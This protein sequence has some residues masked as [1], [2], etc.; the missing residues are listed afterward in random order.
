MER[1]RADISGRASRWRRKKEPPQVE[2]TETGKKQ[3]YDALAALSKA[4]LVF[5]VSYGA[6]GGFLNAYS[7]EFNRV[8]CMGGILGLSLLL[9]FVYE[10]EKKWFTNLCVI[11]I[12]IIYAY[13]AVSRFYVLNSGTYA[14]INEVY[15]QA[16]A[17]LG[18]VGGG[19][20]NLQVD[21]SYLTI[22]SI[23]LFIGVVLVILMVIRLQYKASLIRTI[24]MTFTLYL[25]PIYFEKTP[26][27]F[28]LFLLLSGYVTIGILQCAKVKKHL[29]AQ[30]KQALP[31][32]I[33]I[34]GAIVL[35]FAVLLPKIRYRAMVPKNAAKAAT[36]QDAALFAQYGVMALFMNNFAGGGIN[37]G[38]L[39]QN[40]TMMPDNEPDLLV[41]Y[42]PYSMDPVYLKAFTG[43]DY[44]GKKW[45]KATEVLGPS[46]GLLQSEVAG[47]AQLYERDS[48]AQARGVMEV[49]C[50]D[51]KEMFSFR[52][53]YAKVEESNLLP[54]GD[55]PEGAIK[56][57]RY[58]YYPM[59]TDE[60]VP[61]LD[62]H[63]V[64]N[65]YLNVP[66]NC[67]SAVA[68]ACKEAKLEGSAEEIAQQITEF[69]ASKYRYTLRPGYYFGSMDYISYFLSK[70]KKGFCTHFAS[71]GTMMLRYMG[72]PA[73]Y[74]EGYVFTYT[75]VVTDGEILENE[76]YEDY[77][78]G[79]APLGDTA[80]LEVEVPDAQGHAWIEM[81]LVDKG[82]VVVEVTPA[83][84]AEEEEETGGFWDAIM[85]AGNQQNS[86]AAK[87]QQE[88]AQYIENALAGGVTVVGVLAGIAA[89][90][91]FLRW[92]LGF[93]KE[94][95]LPA[96][97]R[98]RL[99]YGRMTEW[100]KD[101]D[102]G[103]AKL[104]TPEEELSWIETWYGLPEAGKL[105][106]GIYRTFFAPVDDEGCEELRAQ[107]HA[108]RKS[109]R[110]TKR[111]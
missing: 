31:I 65:R 83:A 20:Y 105:K 19:L 93:Y 46:E 27:T 76:N 84:I 61:G 42:T 66:I 15:E 74:V 1:T 54:V 33:A 24:L 60:S 5:M 59:V 103:F 51:P 41:R 94:S 29:S 90:V 85:N 13:M 86:E 56:G 92:L 78:D 22:T 70:N 48:D 3:K 34:G 21:D 100:L 14:V 30:I 73:R 98:L 2:L 26:D 107:V 28:C 82:W 39:S 53:Y 23:S 8:L 18:V 38:Q 97:E 79:Y 55:I 71:A 81:Y 68:S 75:D 87:A 44:D 104:T 35:I 99:E 57:E 77:Y 45:S 106:E 88:A 64:D 109:V 91:L 16:Q 80:V 17:Y 49:Y 62:W 50:L 25:V 47:R 63:E 67:R 9:S 89:L 12:F 72:I 37:E 32:G 40:V 102:E 69:F 52:P 10:T 111:R 4:L 95:K 7:I 43:V 36:E 96:K 101:R 11:G 110:R 58:V 6:V 108:L